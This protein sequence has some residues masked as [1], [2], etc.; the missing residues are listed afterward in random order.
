MSELP[1]A[2]LR[3]RGARDRLAV[4][5]AHVR[6][7]ARH[8]PA[9]ARLVWTCLLFGVAVAWILSCIV[10]WTSERRDFHDLPA[11]IELHDT[12]HHLEV[13]EVPAPDGRGTIRT[14]AVRRMPRTAPAAAAAAAPTPRD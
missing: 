6:R 11:V 10:S 5:S 8:A 2:R 4:A 14:L 9:I 12:V 1:T 3:S 7:G 13:V